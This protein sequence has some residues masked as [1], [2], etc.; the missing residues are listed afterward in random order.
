M[1]EFYRQVPKTLQENLEYRLE[2]RKR[3]LDDL[4]FRRAMWAACKHDVLFWMNAWCWL[5][6]PRPQIVD[7]T[8][9]PTQI[10]FITWPHQDGPILTMRENLGWKDIGLEK[11]RGQ[12][13]S[14]IGVL[15]ALHDWLFL[16]GAKVS[17]VS[18][19][20]KKADDPEDP[21]SLF[22]K[23][24][25]ELKRLPKWMSGARDA[26]WKRNIQNHTLTN[27]R[28]D[29]RITA[30][31]CTA[32][33]A[34]GG[35]ARWFLM[36]E[37][38][39]WGQPQ[40]EA[41]M[42]ST[43]H[44]TKSRLL[45]STPEGTEGAYA[46][47]MHEPSNMIRLILDWKDNPWQNQGLYRHVKGRPT[48]IDPVNNPLPPNYEEESRELHSQLRARGFKLDGETRSPWY[49]QECARTN[50]TPQSIA[51][52]LDRD[53][54]GSMFRIFGQDFFRQTEESV[55]KPICRGVLDFHPESMDPE[56]D[57][58]ENGPVL[59]WTPLD[60]L[61]RPP[62]HA[63]AAAA[64]VSTGLGGSYTSN[65]VLTVIDMNTMEQ[66]L[67]FSTNTMAEE[68]FADFCIVVAKW[69]HNAYLSWEHNG[70]GAKFTKRI[71]DKRYPHVYHRTVFTRVRKVKRKEV[72]W[73]TNK[74]TKEVMFGELNRSVKTG[75]LKLR[76]KDLITECGQYVRGAD[77]KI[78]H[79]MSQEDDDSSKG[80][81]H[82]DR[83]ISI[84]V[85]LQ[86]VRDRPLQ[87]VEKQTMDSPPP[88]TMAARMKEYEDSLKQDEDWDDRTNWDLMRV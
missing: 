87:V 40:D 10:P 67:E 54:G 23:I 7:G 3:S 83:V 61:N 30:Y 81:S 75:E 19:T 32:D 71:V 50:A 25:W 64:D 46:R 27:L 31:A 4:H 34:R 65:S 58:V 43:Q 35:R 63:Y 82:G 74:E 42:R 62:L 88:Y 78:T 21:D 20:E 16:P 53:Y 51:K 69:F 80:E 59:L 77:G 70:P 76:S 55:R 44:V 52:E 49:D 33:I 48:A 9:L 38:A 5:Y 45:V 13:A 15:L 26:D 41:A 24:D 14:W 2:L 11:S 66:V 17:I 72:G 12:G 18:S 36:D 29:S 22:W 47:A 85:C 8:M 57:L 6:E 39:S 86:A 56:F 73:F 1:A 60:V 28:N 84:A 68:D 37:L 79:V